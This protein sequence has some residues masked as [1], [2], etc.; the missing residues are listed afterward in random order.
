MTTAVVQPKLTTAAAEKIKPREVVSTFTTYFPY[1]PPRTENIT[2]A[3]RTLNGTYVGPGEQFSLNA[4]LGQRTAAKGYNAAPVINNGRLTKDYGGG[5]SQ[6]ST[7]TFN[8]AFFSGV[9]ID[10]Y[11]AAQLLHLALPRGP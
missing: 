11:L 9:R 2:I 3:A 6:L 7:T 8:A 10:Q 1:N 4:V 5:I